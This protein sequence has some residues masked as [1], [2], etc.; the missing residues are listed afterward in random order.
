MM[1]PASSTSSWYMVLGGR[2]SGRRL[3]YEATDEKGRMTEVPDER[4]P[5]RS[6]PRQLGAVCHRKPRAGPTAA[7][8]RLHRRDKRPE[9]LVSRV[10]QW[11]RVPDADAGVGTEFRPLHPHP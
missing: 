2:W 4:L 6:L 1:W 7:S 11:A 3:W 5:N 9:A 8:R 10:R